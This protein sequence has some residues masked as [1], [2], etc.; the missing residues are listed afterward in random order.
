[1]V[2]AIASC[3]VAAISEIHAMFPQE[4]CPVCHYVVKDGKP[5]QIEILDQT[6]WQQPGAVY[7]RIVD[8]VVVYISATDGRLSRRLEAHLRNLPTSMIGR[9]EQ[10]RRWAEGKTITVVAF[11]PAP[12]RL[13]G[14]EIKIHRAVEAALI[15]E[16]QRRDADDWFVDP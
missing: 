8:G 1:M 9:A 4:F 3:S 14:R 11:C 7:A 16:F 5:S 2:C 10:F 12:V 6:L 13:L 15:A